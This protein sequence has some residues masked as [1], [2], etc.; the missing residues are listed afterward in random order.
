MRVERCDQIR[1]DSPDAP[2]RVRLF[3]TEQAKFFMDW[4]DAKSNESTIF[5][6]FL[7]LWSN[8]TIRF[9]TLSF[10]PGYDCATRVITIRASSIG[11]ASF[12]I[13]LD[14]FSFCTFSAVPFSLRF[15]SA[16][17]SCLTNKIPT[18]LW[19]CRGDETVRAQLTTS[20]WN[21]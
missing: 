2:V 8:G 10:L 1:P 6:E 5:K 20:W 19:Q 13:I 9:V 17:P 3:K 21:D 14:P 12:P 16:S 18:I 15:S 7:S 11:Q 4:K